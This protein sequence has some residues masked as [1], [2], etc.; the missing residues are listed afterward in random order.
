MN[1]VLLFGLDVNEVKANLLVLHALMMLRHLVMRWVMQAAELKRVIAYC[2]T[3]HGLYWTVLAHVH[4]P[5]LISF[6][7]TLFKIII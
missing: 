5:I 6:I 3:G 7:R 1:F 2:G 4:I